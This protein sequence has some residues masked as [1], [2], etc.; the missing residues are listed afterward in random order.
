MRERPVASSGIHGFDEILGGG[1]P[2]DRLFLIE[3]SPGTG[4]TTL[5]LQFLLEGVR[6]GEQ[7]LYV[8]LSE[9][10]L[11][12]Q[13]VADSHGWKLDGIELYE[14]EAL[15]DRLHPEEEYTVFHPEEV[16]LSETTRKIYAEVE[17]IN[18]RRV[19][20]DSLSEMRLLAR[21]ALR[22]RRQI[23]AVKQFFAG[24]ACTVLLLD[25]QSSPSSDQQLQSICHGVV[26]LQKIMSEFGT[27]RR[28]LSVT[29]LRGVKFRDGN[30]D[31]EIVPGG[32]ITY[33]RLVAASSRKLFFPSILE[34]GVPGLDALLGGGINRGSS[35]L[36]LGPAGSG[37]SSVATLFA[38]HAAEKGE[39][40]AF[41]LFEESTNTFMQR[42]S[43]IGM[44][45]Q[46]HLDSGAITIQQVDPAE[47]SPGE[48][49]ARVCTSV[50]KRNAKIVVIDSLNGYVNSMPS[51]QLLLL[52]MHELLTY[53]G[54]NEVV[55]FLT[56]AQQGM[57][58]QMQ[59]PVDVSY[60]ADVVILMRF[61]EFAGELRQ[62][63][64]V[65]KK[66]NGA[67]ERT[68]REIRFTA[69]GPMLSDVLREFRG[70]LT[71]VPA[72][73]AREEPVLKK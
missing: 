32:L 39:H 54:Q 68:L 18:P 67:H 14:L 63:I 5:A 2:R 69:S 13:D 40:A 24:R 6:L 60:L 57:L 71:G 33:P 50:E 70:V 73:A 22:F 29:K 30:H 34:S 59:S 46:K 9:T 23:L 55:T 27:P 28:R 8:T 17:R 31:I 56:V 38:Y 1:F 36:L 41:Y 35:T 72:L 48:F 19:V 4:K 47:L 25:D 3:G 45:L 26:L 66:R 52:Q 20:F 7:G 42:S 37:K 64:S 53:L 49:T 10:K 43:G 51:D 44:D 62:A 61:F 11:E 21:D 65:V 58:G 12:L 15:E 16:E